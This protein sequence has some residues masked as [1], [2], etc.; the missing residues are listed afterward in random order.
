LNFIYWLLESCNCT[1]ATRA[2]RGRIAPSRRRILANLLTSWGY[3]ATSTRLGQAERVAA[4]RIVSTCAADPT[5]MH[6]PVYKWQI[7]FYFAIYMVE[8]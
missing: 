2:L 1:G 8:I 5:T 6:Q 7:R 3:D 4:V